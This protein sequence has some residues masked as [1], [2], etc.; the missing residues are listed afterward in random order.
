M[1]HLCK[2]TLTIKKG[3]FVTLGNKECSQTLAEQ[4]NARLNML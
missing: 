1:D 2:I 3:S 4:T